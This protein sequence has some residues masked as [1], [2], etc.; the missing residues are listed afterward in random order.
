LL[1]LLQAKLELARKL[2]TEVF[3]P[4]ALWVSSYNAALVSVSPT[5]LLLNYGVIYRAGRHCPAYDMYILYGRE[6]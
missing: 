4:L 3:D 5:C 1:P 6:K 2:Q